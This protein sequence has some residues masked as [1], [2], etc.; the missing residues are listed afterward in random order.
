[1]LNKLKKVVGA[2][3][4]TGMMVYLMGTIVTYANNYPNTPFE[5]NFM[6]QIDMLHLKWDIM[7]IMIMLLM[8]VQEERHIS[9]IQRINIII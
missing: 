5:F 6:Q 9:L 2:T 4:L 1:M 7:N 8:I 3:M